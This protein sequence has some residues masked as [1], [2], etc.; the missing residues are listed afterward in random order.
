[1]KKFSY[2]ILIILFIISCKS[3]DTK[4]VTFAY[5]QEYKL[6]SPEKSIDL[7]KEIVKEYEDYNKLDSINIPLNKLIVGKDYKIY[8]GIGLENTP[9][10]IINHFK[11]DKE[12][13]ILNYSN[14][15]SNL[16][17]LC[18]K[19]NIYAIKYIFTEKKEN[20]PV[21]FNIV[22]KDSILIDNLFKSNEIISKIK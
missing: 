19:N 5:N 1:M 10:E 18:K 12:L 8:I 11:S 22:S 9:L 3:N 15:N 16:N 2:I 13:K 21:V 6:D 4:V 17:L 14:Y 7:S 20:L